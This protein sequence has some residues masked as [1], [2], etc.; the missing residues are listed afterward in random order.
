MWDEAE[1]EVD[2]VS[3]LLQK[4]LAVKAA[5]SLAVIKEDLSEWLPNLLKIDINAENFMTVLDTGVV[6][7]RL[8]G[9][10]QEHTDSLKKEGKLEQ[11]KLEQPVP[12]TAIKYKNSAD[13]GSFFARDNAANFIKWCRTYK[14]GEAILFESDDLVM[15]KD[16]KLVVLTLLEVARRIA[17]LGMQS[18]QLAMMEIAIDN[19]EDIKE[20]STP[21]PLKVPDAK[22]PPAKKKRLP[23]N[24]VDS[25][26]S[27]PYL[28]VNYLPCLVQVIKVIKECQCNP[29]IFVQ[30]HGKGKFCLERQGKEIILF[31]RVGYSVGFT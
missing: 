1:D 10:I 15:H 18:T 8:V 6:L 27:P 16:E 13:H 12:M 22:T 7:C 23:T 19:D 9:A 26:K 20:P 24:L 14:I 4:G 11:P 3:P 25:V 5:E 30:H 28:I 2:T 21:P 17:K 31:A 29:Q